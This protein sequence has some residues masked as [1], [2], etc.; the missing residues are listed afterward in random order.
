[1]TCEKDPPG[2]DKSMTLG[3]SKIDKFQMFSNI[4]GKYFQMIGAIVLSVFNDIDTPK[5]HENPSSEMR[6]TRTVISET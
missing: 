5:Y 4:G 2:S 6:I 1:M 3:C